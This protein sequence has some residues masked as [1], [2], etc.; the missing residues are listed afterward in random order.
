MLE[1]YV[2]LEKEYGPGERVLQ[3]QVVGFFMFHTNDKVVYEN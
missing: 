3:E 2:G 1:V